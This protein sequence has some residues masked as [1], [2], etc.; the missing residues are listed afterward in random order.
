[1]T[2]IAYRDGVLAADSAVSVNDLLS[3]SMRKIVCRADGDMAG[4]AGHAAY[5]CRFLEWF[6]SGET[7][8]APKA[9]R[10][11]Y[12]VDR[13]VIFRRNGDIKI[14]E[15][16]GRSIVRAP[17]F[18]I[19]SGSHL[20]IG[21]MHAGASAPEAVRAAIAHDPYSGGDIVVLSRA[22]S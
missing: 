19:G 7:V 10:G 20:A 12:Y 3:A 2:T 13:G 4:A 16:L 18:A 17:Y 6:S 1:M 22:S 9:T 15:E 5:C 21:A 14:Y 8:E 11:D